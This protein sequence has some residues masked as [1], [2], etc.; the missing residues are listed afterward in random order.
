MI[1]RENSAFVCYGYKRNPE[2]KNKLIID[3]EV[4]DVIKLIF[5]L[6]EQGNGVTKIAQILNDKGILTPTKYKQSQGSNFKN[7]NKNIEYWCES[8]VS[9]ILKSE[10]YIGNLVQGYNKKLSYKSK[11][12]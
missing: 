3:N 8:T 1:A 6:Y 10:V 7:Q 9:K 11:K 5:D 4:S 12:R 2:N